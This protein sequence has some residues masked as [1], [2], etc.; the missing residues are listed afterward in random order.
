MSFVRSVLALAV[1]LVLSGPMAV[2]AAGPNTPAEWF[3]AG[4]QAVKDAKNRK[5][6]VSHAT[7]VILFVGDGMGIAT[8]TAARIL[9]GQM[10]GESGEENLLSFEKF[11]YVA[12][13]K[14]YSVNQQTPD[15]APT[16]TAIV[17]GVKT[18]D[19]LLSVNQNGARGDHTTA[20]GNKLTTIL[21]LAED[22]GLATGVVT[23]TRVT[24]ATPAACYAHTVERDWEGDADL[25]PAARTAGFPDIA[26]QLIEFAHGDGLE[27]ALGGGRN[28]F[29]PS[30]TREAHS[31]ASAPPERS[32]AV[33]QHKA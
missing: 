4:R 8:V 3:A 25:S 31:P 21:E 22:K 5:T 11:P 19:G 1:S 27:V 30:T 33:A 13:S 16:M 12:L 24:H 29:L 20:A 14:T 28:K 7:N 23:T 10:R 9:E 17:T 18:K 15:S 6:N 26:R 2:P 32:S